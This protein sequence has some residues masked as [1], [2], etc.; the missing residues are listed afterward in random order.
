MKQINVY[1]DDLEYE[2]L[3]KNKKDMSWRVFILALNKEKK[4]LVKT[5]PKRTSN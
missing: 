3:I 2:A 4:E 5:S 1:F